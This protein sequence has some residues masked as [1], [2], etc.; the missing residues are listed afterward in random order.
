MLAVAL[1]AQADTLL[2]GNKSADT[3]WALDARSGE[4]LTEFATGAGPHEVA[5]APDGKLAAVANYGARTPNNTLT[6]IGWPA[7]RVLRTVDL[8]ENRRPHGLRFLPD[9]RRV[10]VTTEDSER[11]LVVDVTKGRVEREIAVGPGL[12]HM[13]ALS[14]DARRA[15]VA[16][17]D[18]GRISVVDLAEGQKIGEV[19]TG[20]GAEGVAVTPDGREIWVGNRADDTISVIDAASLKITHTLASKA[21][22][23]RV[24]ITPDG[25]HA[26]VTNARSA[27]LAVFDVAGKREIARIPLAQPGTEYRDTLLGK[28]ALPIGAVVHPDGSRAFVAISG[29]DEIAVIDTATWKIVARWKTGRE[30]DALAVIGADPN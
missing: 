30:P 22:P 25:H 20:N 16:H 8:G 18:G 5:V 2:V 21:F 4:K 1:P 9:G 28:A 15:Y 6:V 27:E 29:G 12:G 11:L 3:L 7:R 10:V 14:P 17:I 23:I 24:A 19:A 13:V 26:L